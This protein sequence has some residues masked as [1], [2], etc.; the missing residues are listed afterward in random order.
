MK[1]T[2]CVI[3]GSRAEYGLLRPLLEKLAAD[4]A[5]NLQLVVTGSHLSSAFGNTQDEITQDGFAVNARIPVPLE[6]DSKTDM[7][8][9]TGAAMA[10]FG[11][12]FADHMPALLIVLGDRFEIFAAAAAA[13]MLSVP[14][15]HIHG[16]ETTEGA[17]D[18]FLRHSITKMSLYHFT[19]CETYRHRVIQLGEAPDRV[20]NVGAL[21][22]ENALHMPL[23][24]REALCESL[25]FDIIGRPYA[26]VTYHPV[27][28]ENNTA[29]EQ[30]RKLI[31]AM[32][33]YPSMA[34]LITKANADAGG[35]LVNQIWDAEAKTHSNWL[36][37]ASLG[38]QRYL[39]ALKYAQ[40]ML[41]NSSSGIIE[42]PAMHIPTVN[43][44][45]RQKGRM[46]A[47]S[48]ICCDIAAE[49]VIQAIDKALSSEYKALVSETVCPFGDGKT[50]DKMMRILR[51]VLQ[52]EHNL[53]KPFYD[54]AFGNEGSN[55]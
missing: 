8:A 17:V 46:M 12:Y 44:G 31:R 32:E 52:K 53:K 42:S 38:A 9:A 35:R 51:S 26:I 50:S 36:V 49:N 22:V 14:I 41:G 15:A 30:V 33:A 45:D 40:M 25:G 4:E 5:F 48:V 34:F 16:G 23:L 10:L 55:V 19:A 7:V 21:G 28:L 29:Q 11:N 43:I 1:H 18:E 2:V 24:S 27:T 39:S 6:G 3:T 20:F 54:L 13:A 47:K 37:T